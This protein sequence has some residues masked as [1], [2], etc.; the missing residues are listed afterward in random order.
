MA[1]VGEFD[2]LQKWQ[3]RARPAPSI[4]TTAAKCRAWLAFANA[5]RDRMEPR[6]S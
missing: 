4:S 1:A 6:Y 2:I 3:Y 5:D